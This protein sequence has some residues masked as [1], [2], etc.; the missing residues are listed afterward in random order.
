MCSKPAMPEVKEAPPPPTEQSAM[1]Q[2]K[3]KQR[4]LVA[5]RNRS[6][7][8]STLLTGS[9]GTDTGGGNLLKPTLGA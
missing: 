2:A 6:G 5:R 3:G 4:D 8:L 7:F 1:L 9:S